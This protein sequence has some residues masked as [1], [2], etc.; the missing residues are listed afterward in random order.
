MRTMLAAP[1][2]ARDRRLVPVRR[3][4]LGYQRIPGV[5]CVMAVVQADGMGDG[6]AELTIEPPRWGLVAVVAGS[7]SS[8]WS[9]C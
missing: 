8:V 3:R 1:P 6:R 4:A 5:A 9:S 2:T 7:G